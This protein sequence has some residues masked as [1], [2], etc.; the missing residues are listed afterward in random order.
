M[1]YEILYTKNQ[2]DTLQQ[3]IHCGFR[4]IDLNSDCF[5]YFY[6]GDHS[7][8]VLPIIDNNTIYPSIIESHQFIKGL[9]NK[10]NININWVDLSFFFDHIYQKNN[11]SDNFKL[12]PLQVLLASRELKTMYI[13]SMEKYCSQLN[14]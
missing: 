5:V 9:E 3:Y 1:V 4:Q 11:N 14:N 6:L 12:D 13:I 2:Y 8:Q 7:N 10:F